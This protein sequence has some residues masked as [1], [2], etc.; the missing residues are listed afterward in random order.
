MA[1]N[2][3]NKGRPTK[4]TDEVRR[5][6]EEVAALD[7]SVEEMAYYSGVHRTT[8]YNWLQEDKDFFDRIQELRERPILKARQT[9]VKHLE[10]PNNAFKYLEKKRRKEFGQNI[11]VTTDGDKLA[12]LL[13]KI[14][15]NDERDSDGDTRGV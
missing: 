1:K 2:K 4:L 6:I 7:G 3:V 8:L 11:D 10:D 15:T 13:V 14:I 5:K 9:V 12:P